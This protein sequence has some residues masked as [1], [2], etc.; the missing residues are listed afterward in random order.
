MKRFNRKNDPVEKEIRRKKRQAR[1]RTEP[2]VPL[3]R[4]EHLRFASLLRK[5]GL[6]FIHVPNEGRRTVLQGR[7]LKDMGLVAGVSDFLIFDAPPETGFVGV[8]IEM[9]RVKRSTT[10][11]AQIDFLQSVADRGWLACVT[12]GCEAAGEVLVRAGF[13][14]GVRDE[15]YDSRITEIRPMDGKKRT[16]SS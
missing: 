11:P 3:E 9:K 1:P 16:H 5:I 4:E 13:V 12:K 2:D 10:S 8:A 15:K 14:K 6:Y 7:R